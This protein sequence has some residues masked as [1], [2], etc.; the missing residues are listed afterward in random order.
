MGILVD[1]KNI[2]LEIMEDLL[3][4]YLAV[5][6]LVTVVSVT[7]EAKNGA[8]FKSW[9]ILVGH[10]V[11]S[12]WRVHSK[13]KVTEISRMQFTCSVLSYQLWLSESEIYSLYSS[14]CNY[15]ISWINTTDWMVSK[16]CSVCMYSPGSVADEL[17][18]KNYDIESI[19]YAYSK[20]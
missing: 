6:T 1:K 19:I 17:P 5:S 4:L 20:G 10:P 18:S 16:Y 7:H 2:L 14:S 9:E 8:R 13:K 12:T 3:C 11:A 15:F